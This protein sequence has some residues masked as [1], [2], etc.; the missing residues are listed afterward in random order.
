M[1]NENTPTDG[2]NSDKLEA[3][4][5]LRDAACSS[6]ISVDEHMPPIGL[7][8]LTWGK[9]TIG[10]TPDV[11]RAYNDG[12]WQPVFKD[13]WRKGQRFEITHWARIVPPSQT[14]REL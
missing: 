3:E 13:G 11:N 9:S 14:N 6:W 7:D 5:A 1:T 12:N 4:S 2:Q 10:D 8:V